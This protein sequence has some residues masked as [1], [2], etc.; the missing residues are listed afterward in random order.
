MHSQEILSTCHRELILRVPLQKLLMM[1]LA[2]LSHVPGFSGAI[3]TEVPLIKLQ[4]SDVSNPAI[5]KGRGWSNS[6][7]V[8]YITGDYWE[9]KN[10]KIAEGGKG[11]ILDNANYCLVKD[12]EIYNIGQEGL[13]VRDGSSN[14]TIDGVNLHDIGKHNDGYGEGIY[15]GSDN[16]VWKEGDGVNTGENGKLYSREVHYTTIKNCTIGPNITAEPIDIKEG[17]TN[18]VVENC[19][20]KGSG[21][22]GVNYADSHIDIKGCS[23]RIRYNTFYQDNNSNIK[24]SIMIVPRQNAGV[25][26]MYTARDN[27]IHDNTFYLDQTDV[28]VLVANSGSVNTYAWANTR[29]PS[30]NMYSGDIT[31]NPPSGYDPGSGSNPPPPPPSSDNLKV[32]Y[33]CSATSSSTKTIKPDIKLVNIG[34]SDLGLADYSIRYWFTRDSLSPKYAERYVEFGA[35]YADGVFGTAPNGMDYLQINLSGGTIEA[36]SSVTIKVS[37]SNTAYK[38]YTQTNDYSFDSTFTSFKD[39]SKITLYKNGAL[40]WGTEP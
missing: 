34:S 24:R 18:T 36:E 14:T 38:Y 25:P 3:P 37:I 27:Y 5:L 21:I 12:V 40:V 22:S 15:V 31:T 29:I 33:K 11:L 26:D 30:G 10:I 2:A 23:A 4:S 32:Q 7:Y 35:S 20:I 13:H 19:T 39:Y 9:I 16:S 17:T 6:E 1:G 28:E 8:L